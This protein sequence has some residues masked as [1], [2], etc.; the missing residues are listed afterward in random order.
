MRARDDTIATLKAYSDPL[1]GHDEPLT[2][3]IQ[4]HPEFPQTVDVMDVEKVYD[5]L[6]RLQPRDTK[7]E[8]E[9]WAEGY[10]WW[11]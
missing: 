10:E 6:Q 7:K 11:D 1:L 2:M 8:D 5:V 3:I 9:R 4:F